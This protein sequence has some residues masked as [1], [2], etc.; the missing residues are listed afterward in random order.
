MKNVIRL[1]DSTSHGGKVLNVRARHFKVAQVPVACVG[2]PCSC[3]KPGHSGCTIATGSKRHRIDG[4]A[5]A[6]D[7][8]VTSCGAK[9]QSS[10]TNFH[11]T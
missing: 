7:G 6:Y 10:L 4:V 5:V 11:S 8:D 3:P 9:L 2:D 1:G